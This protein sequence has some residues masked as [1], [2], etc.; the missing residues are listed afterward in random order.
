MPPHIH[1]GEGVYAALQDTLGIPAGILSELGGKAIGAKEVA[2]C[3]FFLGG[4]VSLVDF[5]F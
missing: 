4:D 5:G 1:D 3:K 2:Y